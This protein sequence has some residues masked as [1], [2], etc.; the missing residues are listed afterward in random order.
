SVGGELRQYENG[1]SDSFNPVFTLSGSYRPA[2]RTTVS[3][4]GY[5]QQN[6]Q[7]FNGYNYTSTG[8]N[9]G[10]SQGITDRFTADV[11]VGYFVLDFQSITSTQANYSEN[12][13]TAHFGLQAKIVRHLTSQIYYDLTS[14]Q[15]SGNGDINDNKIGV[16]LTL[17]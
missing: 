15:R 3:L 4:T 8:V 9:L 11:S 14:I 13:Y 7:V 6:A 16:N 1:E 10:V 5:A 12:Y 2:E 17:S